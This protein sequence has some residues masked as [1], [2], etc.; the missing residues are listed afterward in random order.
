MNLRGGLIDTR[1]VSNLKADT[2]LPLS[3]ESCCCV[4]LRAYLSI[5]LCCSAYS[6]GREIDDRP[7]TRIEL[8]FYFFYLDDDSL[9]PLSEKLFPILP[10]VTMY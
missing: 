9:T 3:S 5:Y 1:S 7:L 4:S 10:T 2:F 6:K 8:T